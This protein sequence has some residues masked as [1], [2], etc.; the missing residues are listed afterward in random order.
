EALSI[1]ARRAGGSMRDA[2]SLLDQLLAFGGDQLTA[3]QV[4]KLLGTANEERVAALASAVLRGAPGEALQFLSQAAE[5]GL[6]LGELLDQLM[7]YWRD[8]LVVNCAG[9]DNQSLS[10]TGKQRA[11]LKEQAGQ[12]SADTILA[13]LDV[14]VSAKNRMRFTSHGRVVFEMALV[15]LCRLENLVPLAQLAEWIGQGASMPSGRAKAAPP[16]PNGNANVAS[17][18]PHP[19]EKKKLTFDDP[20]TKP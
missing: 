14:L 13:G 1:V 6:Q 3:E 10:A 8:L 2:Q 17:S 7:E 12:L 18:L 4:H 20:K 15:R 5:Q 9:L 16:Q 11:I 19:A